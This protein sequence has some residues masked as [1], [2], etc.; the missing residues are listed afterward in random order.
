MV[1]GMTEHP[2]RFIAGLLAAAFL[3]DRGIGLVLERLYSQVLPGSSCAANAVRVLDRGAAEVLVFGSSRA[4]HHVDP[5]ILTERWGLNAYNLGCQ[6]YGIYL[7]V[8]MQ[9]ILLDRGVE[10]ALVILQVDLKDLYL[11]DPSRVFPLAPLA[12]EEG[13]RPL[14]AK[15]PLVA[16]LKLQSH[17]YRYNSIA[18]NIVLNWLANAP[19]PHGFMPRGGS[20]VGSSARAG[21]PGGIPLWVHESSLGFRPEKEQLFRDFA[22]LAGERAIPSLWIMGPTLRNGQARYPAELRALKR[23]REIAAEE[24]VPFLALDEL[25]HPV[26]DDPSLYTDNRH[27]N[28]DGA[29][30]FSEALV[31]EASKRNPELLAAP[32]GEKLNREPR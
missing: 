27:L 18:V 32:A 23:I 29:T 30:L 31:V 25:T 16:R 13:L 10:P 8:G 26:F 3:F 24:G 15:L 17:A 11:E 14:V 21:S 6:G 4:K 19:S 2:L 12:D 9:R 22:R 28:A 20:M 5:K 1:T 7:A